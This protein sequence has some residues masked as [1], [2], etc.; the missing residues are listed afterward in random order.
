[1]TDEGNSAREVA[2][3]NFRGTVISALLACAGIVLAA[4]IGSNVGRNRAQNE[5]KTAEAQQD[6]ELAAKDKLIAQLRAENQA[7]RQQL[8]STTSA[9]A[10]GGDP[11][12][13]NAATSSDK[14]QHNEAFAF[15]LQSCSHRGESVKCAFT[16][17]AEHRDRRVI[18][19]GSSR[20]I[21]DAG[22]ELL[23]TSISLAGNDS[24]VDRYSAVE[25]DLVRGIAISGTIT[26]EGAS[27][28]LKTAPVIEFVA[29]DGNVQFRSVPLVS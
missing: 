2:R 12:T 1:M 17:V 18:L 6:T 10:V 3:I 27:A 4:W 14:T 16:V 28:T 29:S 23:A 19:W 5:A 9:G 13:G 8:A 20:L 7:L 15:T 24:H 21:D 22:K 25:N 11:I 26:F